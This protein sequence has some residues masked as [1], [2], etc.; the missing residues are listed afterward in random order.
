MKKLTEEERKQRVRE[1][2][3]KYF[4]ENKEKIY[5][6]RKVYNK[7]YNEGRKKRKNASWKKWYER[8]K[9]KVCKSQRDY[10]EKNKEEVLNKAKEYREDNR[11]LVNE[12]SRISRLKHYDKEK[13]K[14]RNKQYYLK[15]PISVIESRHR[16]RAR[17]NSASGHATKEQIQARFDYHGNKCYYCGDSSSR[18]E[19]EHRI[20]LSRG[21]S[22]WPA[23]IVPACKHCN[24]KKHTK[25]EREF[26]EKTM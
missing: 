4:Q 2:N 9:E 24:N 18:L 7:Q 19:I 5:E 13:Q 16:R 12:R 25:T 23:N 21:G 8:N 6:K 10:Y 17:L 26:K 3:K 11:H 15:N 22:N 14:E 20:P 1:R